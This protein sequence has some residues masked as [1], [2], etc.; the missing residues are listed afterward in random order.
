[1]GYWPYGQEVKHREREPDRQ[2]Q[3]KDIGRVTGSRAEGVAENRCRSVGRGR[4]IT[5]IFTRKR[6]GGSG[7]RM[8]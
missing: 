2:S 6:E 7:R 5:T 3:G 4:P 8:K 1:M